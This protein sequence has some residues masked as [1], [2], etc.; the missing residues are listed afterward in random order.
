MMAG[1]AQKAGGHPQAAQGLATEKASVHLKTQPITQ[2]EYVL[3]EITG[4]QITGAA[5]SRAG[6][7]RQ[8]CGCSRR[9]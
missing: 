9:T 8:G 4:T 6:L 7:Q 3:I 2:K 1:E 5:V